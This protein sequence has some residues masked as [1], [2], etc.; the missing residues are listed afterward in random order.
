MLENLFSPGK[1]GNVQ[2][3]NRIIRSATFMRKAERYGQVGQ[4]H[5]DCYKRLAEG[6]VGLIITGFV[7]VDPGGTAA[8]NQASLIDDSYIPGHQKLTKIIHDI[9]EVK[10]AAQLGHTG[11]Q[12]YHPK[13]PPVA[14]SP[15]FYKGTGLT[16]RE[17]STEEV[18]GISK[19]FIDA[20]RRAYESEY[21]I[22]QLHGAHGYLLSNFISPFTN[23]RTDIYG[24]NTENR[25]KIL[26]SIYEGI[27]DEVG[28][29][30][31][32][33]IKLQT[34]DFIQNGL[35]LD[36]AVKVAE[37]LSKTGYDAIEPSGGIGES[38]VDSKITYPSLVVRKP[39][40]ENYFLPNIQKI[41]PIAHKSKLILMGGIKNPV[42]A[43]KLL[44]EDAVDFISMSRPLIREPNLPNRWKNGD[45]TPAK[46]I[47]CN[48]CYMAMM[49]GEVHCVVEKRLEKKKIREKKKEK[50]E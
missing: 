20:S 37:I 14:P 39:E 43:D 13:Y 27:R 22:V 36:E 1:I 12:G 2:I 4:S 19:I 23:L 47:R 6:G 50:R 42:S 48:T 34:Q 35:N 41:K 15:I 26:V 9:S 45:L 21:D 30:F 3:K 5:I 17:L 38:F 7:S 46:C 32:I 18:E 44:K 49:S 29:E 10:I 40:D 11:R 16:P 25:T 24:G 33:I 8:P 28:K 31:P